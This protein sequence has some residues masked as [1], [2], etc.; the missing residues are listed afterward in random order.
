[1]RHPLLTD[2]NGVPLEHLV[3]WVKGVTLKCSPNGGCAKMLTWG[4]GSQTTSSD[5][6]SSSDME[7]SA[8]PAQL[9]AQVA[10]FG[11][12]VVELL[13]ASPRCQLPFVKFIPAYHHHFG[14]QCRVA[15]YGFTRLIDLLDALPNVV[16]V[17]TD[18]SFV[19]TLFKLL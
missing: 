4:T 8:S 11:R 2:D 5:E 9:A 3:T 1:M 10:L 16:Q 17:S 13:R 12:E 14:R 15:N 6:N 19:S 7:R 18:F